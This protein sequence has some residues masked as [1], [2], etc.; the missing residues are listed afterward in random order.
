MEKIP[1]RSSSMARSIPSVGNYSVLTNFLYCRKMLFSFSY[2]D[3]DQTL[4]MVI[5]LLL[6]QRI[7]FGN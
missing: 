2:T 5:F 4:Y 1:W 6:K 3:H 7:G